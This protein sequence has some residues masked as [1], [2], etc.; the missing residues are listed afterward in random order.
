MGGLLVIVLFAVVATALWRATRPRVFEAHP[1]PVLAGPEEDDLEPLPDELV[2]PLGDALTAVVK[3]TLEC[4]MELDAARQELAAGDGRGQAEA[5]ERLLRALAMAEEVGR[6]AS[7][8]LDELTHVPEEPGWWLTHVL[9]QAE[10]LRAL[11]DEAERLSEGP[12]TAVTRAAV[13]KGV[14]RA[15][16]LLLAA[17]D[18]SERLLDFDVT[19]WLR[20]EE[21]REVARRFERGAEAALR[22]RA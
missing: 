5:H 17:R 21:G 22:R 7:E 2:Q 10:A 16:E 6:V 9:E 12:A 8:T 18:F 19:G 11:S 15:E 14:E 20:T 1:H 13:G 4:L 3:A